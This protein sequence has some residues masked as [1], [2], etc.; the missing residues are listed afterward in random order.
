VNDEAEIQQALNACA[1]GD[2]VFLRPGVYIISDTLSFGN[3]TLAGDSTAV[4]KYNNQ[5]TWPSTKQ[6][7]INISD[8]TTICGFEIDA[9]NIDI[10]NVDGGVVFYL[11]LSDKR[12][13]NI[14]IHNLKMHNPI[15]GSY[16]Y[17][18]SAKVD[19]FFLYDCI[20]LG[21][22][23]LY[24]ALNTDVYNN[25]ILGIETGY[26]ENFKLHDN[27]MESIRIQNYSSNQSYDVF[28]NKIMY[29]Y[30]NANGSTKL[31]YVHHNIF[32]ANIY[33][34]SPYFNPYNILIENN[35]F[36]NGIII[37]YG[38][39]SF[40]QFSSGT[41]RIRN[42][43]IIHDT[44]YLIVYSN[45]V[46]PDAYQIISENNCLVSPVEK[47]YWDSNFHSILTISN[48]IYA[49]PKFADRANGDY[50]LKSTSGR[51]NGTTWVTD[52]E[53]SP[54]IDAGHP[55]SEYS[56]EPSPNG[57]RIDIGLYGNTPEAS[58]STSPGVGEDKPL[59]FALS[60]NNPNPFNPVTIITYSVP[61]KTPV[62]LEIFDLS[63]KKV[64]ILVNGIKDKGNYSVEWK[65]ENLASGIY[66]YKIEAGKYTETKKMVYIK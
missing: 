7:L 34:S 19:T 29:G 14:D 25:E 43:I 56:N 62:N 41:I 32:Y 21:C 2:T 39:N 30:F 13:K 16:S 42:N 10:S 64:G 1:A 57:G 66:L 50:H 27:Q 53:N 4:L 12:I 63:G 6:H 24:S 44:E 17:F 9:N 40:Y 31:G 58:K 48:D 52:T 47:Y 22:I 3:K 51:W 55:E 36:D 15:Q 61:E 20:I 54:C 45:S 60:Q 23:K 65:P 11:Y 28:N 49:D 33:L 5:I 38:T 8:N 37:I 59:T 26:T 35:I 18:I 46:L